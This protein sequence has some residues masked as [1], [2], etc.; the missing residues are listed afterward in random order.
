M[1][2][3]MIVYLDE[4]NLADEWMLLPFTPPRY[5]HTVQ[6]KLLWVKTENIVFD[7]MGHFQLVT[8]ETPL[9]GTNVLASLAR[10]NFD[11]PSDVLMMESTESAALVFETAQL[12]VAM[13]NPLSDRNATSDVNS[14]ALE[15]IFS[16][17]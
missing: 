14:L 1:V 6:V 9:N 10:V 8:R 12:S 7:A 17:K 3:A 15:V 16:P 11:I 5:A 13:W 4:S 2:Q